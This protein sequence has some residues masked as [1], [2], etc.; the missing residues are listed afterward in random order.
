M[1]DVG[2]HGV[3]HTFASGTSLAAGKAIV[4][5]GGAAGIP[6]GLT[7]AVAASTGS[8]NLGN[9]GDTVTLKN[10]AGDGGGHRHLSP[11][12]S[13]GTDGV[14]VNRSPDATSG[15]TFVLHTT[16]RRARVLAGQARQRRRVL[17]APPG[18]FGPGASHFRRSSL[19]Q[20]GPAS[21]FGAA[22]AGAA[23]AVFDVSPCAAFINV[24]SSWPKYSSHCLMLAAPFRT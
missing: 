24:S 2:R 19:R 16:R 5:F 23:Q 15:G 18:G 8:L 11:R 9:S 12:R 1:D 10:A 21:C 4:V 20:A 13:P 6:G 17:G 3:R 7:N 22:C 14:S